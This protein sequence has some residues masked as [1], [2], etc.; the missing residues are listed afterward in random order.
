MSD[1]S[2]IKQL[3][4]QQTSRFQIDPNVICTI[5]EIESS[6]NPWAVRFEP[7]SNYKVSVD[8]IAKLVRITSATEDMLQKFS[9]GLG[10]IMGSTARWIGFRGP[11][12]QLCEP[13]TAIQW[14][15][16]AYNKICAHYPSQEERFAAYNA[17]SARKKQDGSF[18]N[19][20]YVNKS[21]KVFLRK[22]FDI[23][24]PALL[25]IQTKNP[26]LA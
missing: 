8:E 5:I 11:L 9:W 20:D 14:I 10:Q 21:M 1:L 25:A 15:C 19:Q 17:G 6:Y 12:T 4:I 22:P 3:I 16:E 24:S 26:P 7:N 2:N 13:D 23:P 18:V